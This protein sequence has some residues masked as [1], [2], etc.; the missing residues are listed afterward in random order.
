MKIQTCYHMIHSASKLMFTY[1]QPGE[2][3]NHSQDTGSNLLLLRYL[4]F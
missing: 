2:R 1:I 3:R 4:N